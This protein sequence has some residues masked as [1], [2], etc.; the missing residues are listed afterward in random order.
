MSPQKA[1][2][3]HRTCVNHLRVFGSIVYSHVPDEKKKKLD[4]K[5][6]KCIFIGYNEKSKPYKLFNLLTNKII[7]SRD[8][9]F[10]YEET[11]EWNE[12]EKIQN[13]TL[14]DV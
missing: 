10:Y 11:W 2:S 4:D 1:W 8:V 14:L 13:S 12:N 7:V 9:K 5:L 3:G 6:E